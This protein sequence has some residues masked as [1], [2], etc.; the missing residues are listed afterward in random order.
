[1]RLLKLLILTFFASCQLTQKFDPKNFTESEVLGQNE[2]ILSQNIKNNKDAEYLVR[3]NFILLKEEADNNPDVVI[4]LRNALIEWSVY[5]PI[6]IMISIDD[7]DFGP[8]PFT[9]PTRASDAIL[10]RITDIQAMPL[11]FSDNTLGA[12]D[13]AG[14]ALFLDDEM[15]DKNAKVFYFVCLHEIGH[16]LGLPHI[17]PI[18]SVGAPAGSIMIN[19]NY[20]NNIMVPA[21]SLYTGN[22]HPSL[23]ETKLAKEYIRILAAPFS[24]SLKTALYNQCRLPYNEIDELKKVK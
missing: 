7:T 21:V 4:A 23:L 5:L 8:L 18:G 15:I 3:L 10:V 6:E 20:G 24:F 12:Y 2:F 22:Y 13:G 17:F 16:A 1:M 9:K 11:N 14:H 19:K